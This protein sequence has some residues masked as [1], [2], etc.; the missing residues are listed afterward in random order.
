MRVC[1]EG[2]FVR[3]MTK[4]KN[5]KEKEKKIY[6]LACQFRRKNLIFGPSGNLCVNKFIFY[7]DH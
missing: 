7:F 1:F 5:E 6:Y 3:K 4:C 2:K